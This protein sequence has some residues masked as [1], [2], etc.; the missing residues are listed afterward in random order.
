MKRAAGLFFVAMMVG[1]LGVTGCK[2]SNDEAAMEE[3]SASAAAASDCQGAEPG[4]DEPGATPA[5][6]MGEVEPVVEEAAS[7]FG[8]TAS[9]MRG[10]YDR[11]E[12]RHAKMRERRHERRE[13]MREHRREERR[14]RREHGGHGQWREGPPERR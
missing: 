10:A 11:W 8:R 1:L 6:A 3:G 7:F 13:R 14:E 12:R 9:R 5:V 2:G 4:S